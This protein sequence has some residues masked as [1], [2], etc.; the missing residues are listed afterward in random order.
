MSKAKEAVILLVEDDANDILLFRRALAAVMPEASLIVAANAE[1]AQAY[2]LRP[3]PRVLECLALVLLDLKL[4][5]RSGMELLGWIRTR[6]ALRQVVVVALTSSREANDL[7][8]AYDLGVNSHLV[9][10]TGYEA[11]SAAVK[12][13]CGYWINLNERAPSRAPDNNR[14]VQESA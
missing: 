1:E 9:K 14:T 12:S 3:D 10:P 4:P 5:G 7:R 13:L 2:L 11:L 8:L 6:K